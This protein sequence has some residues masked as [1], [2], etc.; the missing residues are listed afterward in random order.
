MGMKKEE[1]MAAHILLNGSEEYC[2]QYVAVKSFTNRKVIA[3]GDDLVKV[4]SEAKEKGAGDP[5]VFYV[6]EKDVA[7][8]YK[9]L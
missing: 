4:T 2:G 9:C 6:P 3:H 8:I 7:Q 5:V 1:N